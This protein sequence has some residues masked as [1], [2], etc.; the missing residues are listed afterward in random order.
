MQ[1]IISIMR[2]KSN[3]A[4]TYR[5]QWL[6]IESMR[7]ILDGVLYLTRRYIIKGIHYFSVF[8]YSEAD[9]SLVVALELSVIVTFTNLL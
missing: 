8:R 2:R 9:S 7:L 4:G 6:E 1:V 3:S 5:I